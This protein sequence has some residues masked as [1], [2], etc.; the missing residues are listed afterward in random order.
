MSD[1]FRG[2]D[3]A[4]LVSY[5]TEYRDCLVCGSD[6]NELWASFGVYKA[7]QCSDCSFVWMNPFCNNRGLSFYYRDYIGKRRLSDGKKME[8][9]AIQYQEDGRF[10]ENFVK[11]GKLLDV[12]CNGG[13]F[14]ASLSSG[15]DKH[16]VEI[17]MHAVMYAREHHRFGSQVLCVDLME[18]PYEN[19]SFD[20]ITMR[21][22]IEHMPNPAGAIEKISSLLKPGGYYYVTATPNVDSPAAR[23]YREQWTLF[24][25]VQHI[26][27]FSPRTLSIL[28]ERFDLELIAESF[29]YE[30]TPYAD[31]PNDVSAIIDAKRLREAGES[32]PVSGPFWGSMMSL[33][34]RKKNL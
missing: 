19:E 32:L 27:H 8:Q 21:G 17:D 23:I 2:E 20:V 9:R 28:C 31:V 24:H 3:L 11:E 1:E 15:F 10:L 7:V 13:F 30:Q 4:P 22:T 26:Y 6:N 34:F 33:V 25:P 5:L 16:G 12:G 18:S 14:L 29:P